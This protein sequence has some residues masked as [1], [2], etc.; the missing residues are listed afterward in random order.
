MFNQNLLAE[1][2]N[3]VLSDYRLISLLSILSL[4]LQ[5]IIYSQITFW[6]TE[7]NLLD[8]YQA[9]FSERHSTQTALINE[10]KQDA[11]M[12]KITVLVL[13]HF[14]N[15]FRLFLHDVFALK[16]K[17]LCHCYIVKMPHC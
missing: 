17:I 11:D 7:N 10:I 13:L 15:D 5:R 3:S 2:S 16:T 4:V 8:V 1:K 9:E 14:S 12:G 6:L